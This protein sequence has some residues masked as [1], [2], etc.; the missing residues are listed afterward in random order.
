[1]SFK[2]SEELVAEEVVLLRHKLVLE[3]RRY[4]EL[5][6]KRRELS[7]KA[8]KLVLVNNKLNSYILPLRDKVRSLKRDIE[9][10][11]H[12]GKKKKKKDHE[13]CS[14]CRGW[15]EVPCDICE[16]SGNLPKEDS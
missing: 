10:F 2:T 13:L 3:K 5:N 1:M 12:R 6:L 11:R 14:M 4:D 8:R 7:E 15:G 9:I 16:G